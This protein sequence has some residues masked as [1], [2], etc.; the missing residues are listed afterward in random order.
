[1]LK[2]CWTKLIEKIDERSRSTE[3]MNWKDELFWTIGGDHPDMILLR[4]L[5]ARKWNVDEALKQF[6]D[7]IVWRWKWGL[8]QLLFHG[9]SMVDQNELRTGKT[10]FLGF[11][12][13]NRPINYISARAHSKGEYPMESTEKLTVL[14]MEI[15]RKLLRPPV[16]SVVVLFDLTDFSLRNMDYQHV[17]FLINVLQNYY[18]ESLG[19]ALIVNAPWI[20]NSCW[21]VIKG[22]LDPIVQQKIRFVRHLSELNQ[23]IPAD[24]LPKHL[25]GNRETFHYLLPTND[26]VDL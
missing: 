6:L 10:F 2:E 11:D 18:P 1:M 22:W 8:N 9:E 26:E 21:F 16:E 7:T 13:S 15:G 20:F 19:L 12:R 24:L 25:D 4:Y 3:E 14:T 5:R 17:K 23:W